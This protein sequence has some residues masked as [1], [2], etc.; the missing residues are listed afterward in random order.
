[1]SGKKCVLLVSLLFWSLYST[2]VLESYCRMPPQKKDKKKH[3]K[4]GRHVSSFDDIKRREQEE[5]EGPKA[6]AKGGESSS[7]DEEGSPIVKK[8][9]PRLV[10]GDAEK[11]TGVGNSGSEPKKKV[12]KKTEE[13]DDDFD[14]QPLNR[15]LGDEAHQLS[16][17]LSRKQKEEIEKERKKK[18]YE[19][20]HKE[21]KT[22]EAKKD[23]ERL[24]EIRKRRAESA[25][26]REEAVQKEADAK[27]ANSGPSTSA[28]VAALGGEKSR[29]MPGQKVKEEPK[30]RVK[31]EC[32]D[33][34]EAYKTERKADTVP[35]TNALAGS[36][37]ACRLEED[38]FM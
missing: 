37:E 34:Y 22:D 17:G 15:G 7:S 32:G 33:I 12:L 30:P 16:Q 28:Y 19:K 3:Q 5:R 38:D 23:L 29:K 20:L 1:M 2:A 26:L 6:D 24:A 4:Q 21:G 18:A 25:A 13:E 27:K 35:V 8:L 9:D 36:I 10:D 14:I 11:A 31:E